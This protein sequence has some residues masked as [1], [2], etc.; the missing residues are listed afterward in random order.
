[1]VQRPGSAREL[2]VGEAVILLHPPVPSLGVSMGINRDGVKMTVS[3]M[4]TRER[5]ASTRCALPHIL[6]SAAPP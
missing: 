6:E 4:A 3:S 2:A 5:A 1:M